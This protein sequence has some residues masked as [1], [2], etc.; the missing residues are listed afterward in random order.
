MKQHLLFCACTVNLQFTKVAKTN[1]TG[2]FTHS[3]SIIADLCG[4][5]LGLALFS[6]GRSLQTSSNP[7]TSVCL[8]MFLLRSQKFHLLEKNTAVRC[9]A[10]PEPVPRATMHVSHVLL[11]SDKLILE[12]RLA[13]MAI[14]PITQKQ[15]FLFKFP[16]FAQFRFL[17]TVLKLLSPDL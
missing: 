9:E 13:G 16:Y 8:F 14:R 10:E 3:D 7:L 1:S 6:K 12:A 4:C 17:Q 11:S 15:S 5:S 2:R